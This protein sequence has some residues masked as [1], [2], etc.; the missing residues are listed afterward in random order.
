MKDL[1]PYDDYETEYFK[2]YKTMSPSAIISK[3][4]K[5]K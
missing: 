2:Q 5:K 1:K 3:T 4:E